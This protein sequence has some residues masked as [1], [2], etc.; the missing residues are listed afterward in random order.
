MTAAVDPVSVEVGQ[1][2]VEVRR[3]MMGGVVSVMALDD[4]DAVRLERAA[5][6]VLDRIEAWAG[7]LLTG[8]RRAP[9]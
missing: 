6:V 3:P 1:V 5:R 9:N 2:T 7:R 8:S 4:M